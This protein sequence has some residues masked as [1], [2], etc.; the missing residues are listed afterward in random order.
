MEKKKMSLKKK[1]L[2]GITSVIA[3]IIALYFLFYFFALA[4]EPTIKCD[5]ER[6]K[7]ATFENYSMF[8][9]SKN[10]KLYIKQVS[11]EMF[12]KVPKT[13]GDYYIDNTVILVADDGVTYSQIEELVKENNAVICGYIE[14]VGFYQIEFNGDVSFNELEEKCEQLEDNSLVKEANIDYADG[15]MDEDEIVNYEKDVANYYN[16]YSGEGSSENQFDDDYYANELLRSKYSLD[17][18]NAPQAWD[19]AGDLKPVKVAV[20]DGATDYTHPDLDIEDRD[21]YSEDFIKSKSTPLISDHGTHV[22]GIISAL[23]N[24]EGTDGVCES[25][26]IYPY[27]V[28]FGTDSYFVA[29]MCDSIAQ[30]KVKVINVSLGFSAD[31]TISASMGDKNAIKFIEEETKM[32]DSIL[33]R[34]VKDGNDFLMCISSGNDGKIYCYRDLF[35]RYDYSEKKLLDNI[36]YQP[37]SKTRGKADAKYNFWYQGIETPEVKDRIIV[38]GAGLVLNP[39]METEYSE[40]KVE[41]SKITETAEFSTL[42]ERVDIIAPEGSTSTISHNAYYYMDGTSMS[43]PF[44]AGTAA[45]LFAMD[46][47]LTAPEVKDILISTASESVK[48]PNGK[49]EYPVLNAENAVKYVA[50]H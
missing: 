24:D 29:V 34:L 20:Y 21:N 38:V 8:D 40:N 37:F 39:D 15:P 47:T 7:K 17:A 3:I 41:K 50:E 28:E 48:D 1:I 30:E 35:G 22:S 45:L 13:D 18:I 43:S 16:Y 11:A 4:F 10:D 46:D 14:C 9:K 26:R 33:T 42:G 44:T 25:A 6:L 31:I 32:I 5:E 19:I 23:H 12:K 49:L 27:C 36:F 2:I